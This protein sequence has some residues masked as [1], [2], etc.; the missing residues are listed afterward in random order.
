MGCMPLVPETKMADTHKQSVSGNHWPGE[1][2]DQCLKLRPHLNFVLR[3]LEPTPRHVFSINTS[4]SNT[5]ALFHI[6]TCRA[7][8]LSSVT[9]RENTIT[10]SYSPAAVKR[11]KMYRPC[12]HSFPQ[13]TLSVRL[14]PASKTAIASN[15]RK[16]R[17][18][19]NT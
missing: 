15:H 7:T 8:T 1:P 16:K 18:F 10:L 5:L 2:R 14:F 17:T 3:F 6:F 19:R 13:Y 11:H 12:K 9:S 4:S